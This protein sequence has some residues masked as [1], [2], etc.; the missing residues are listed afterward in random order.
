[1]Y[2]DF[3]RV[4]RKYADLSYIAAYAMG[5][6]ARRGIEDEHGGSVPHIQCVRGCDDPLHHVLR[7]EGGFDDAD[8]EFGRPEKEVSH[9]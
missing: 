4:F 6:D 9:G 3:E 2:G 5:V 7:S 1:M 8:W